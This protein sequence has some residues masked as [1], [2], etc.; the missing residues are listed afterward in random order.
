MGGL[1]QAIMLNNCDSL[2]HKFA[3]FENVY[4]EHCSD[5]KKILGLTI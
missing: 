1:N 5:T 4:G 3:V 2:N